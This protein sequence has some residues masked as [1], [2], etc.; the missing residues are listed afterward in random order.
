MRH[1]EFIDQTLYAHSLI[2][3][4]QIFA[5]QIFD[6]SYRESS[7]VRDVTNNGWDAPEPGH[8]GCMPTSLTRNDLELTATGLSDK[9]RLDYSFRLNRFRK[10]RKRD[11]VNRG[12]RLQASKLKLMNWEVFELSDFHRP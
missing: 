10:L 9:Y 1:S 11:A 12:S 2:D 7:P 6:Q 4:S 3:R 5:M 8:P